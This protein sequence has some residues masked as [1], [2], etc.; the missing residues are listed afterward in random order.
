MENGKWIRGKEEKGNRLLVCNL[1][2]LSGLHL[3]RV[4]AGVLRL[5]AVP[6]PG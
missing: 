2:I 6:V 1:L 3:F 5:A 4:P